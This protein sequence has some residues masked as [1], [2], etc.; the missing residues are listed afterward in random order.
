M[1]FC[2]VV[3]I[4][5]TVNT[6]IDIYC[7]LASRTEVLYAVAES[8]GLICV[9]YRSHTSSVNHLTVDEGLLVGDAWRRTAECTFDWCWCSVL[10]Q[11]WLAAGPKALLVMAIQCCVVR[12]RMAWPCIQK[13]CDFNSISIYSTFHRS[14]TM[15]KTTRI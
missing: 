8:H 7:S 3:G 12:C 14:F 4:T 10:V 6:Y 5:T 1:V 2:K 13:S 9:C 11:L 15:S